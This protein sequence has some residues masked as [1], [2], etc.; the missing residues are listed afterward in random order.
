MRLP[1][2]WR[3][4]VSRNVLPLATSGPGYNKS[5]G[6]ALLRRGGALSQG[7][8]DAES[9]FTGVAEVGKATLTMERR[10]GSITL[11]ENAAAIRW[12]RKARVDP[13]QRQAR[14][15]RQETRPTLDR[16]GACGG[17]VVRAGN[18]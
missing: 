1:Q 5:D 10:T 17:A 9:R 16:S 4:V 8:R 15:V 6:P 11:L 12:T 3:T 2:L 14:S 7:K 13:L 18:A